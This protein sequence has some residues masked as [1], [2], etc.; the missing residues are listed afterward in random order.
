MGHVSVGV[1]QLGAAAA[2]GI[3]CSYFLFAQSAGATVVTSTSGG[4]VCVADPGSCTFTAAGTAAFTGEFVQ[5][6]PAVDPI[7]CGDQVSDSQD[8]IC[9]HFGMDFSNQTGTVTVLIA[10]DGNAADIDLCVGRGAVPGADIVGCSLG[11]GSSETVTF[12]VACTDTRFE[13]LILPIMYFDLLG[14]S[15][16]NPFPYTGSAVVT[17]LSTCT[18]GEGN[19]PPGGK[20]ATGHKITGGGK[21]SPAPATPPSMNFSLNVIA[22]ASGFKGKVQCSD[23]TTV[24]RGTEIDTVS[25]DDANQRATIFGHGFFKDAPNT[26]VPFQAEGDDQGEGSSTAPPGDIFTIDKCGGG[27]VVASGNVQYHLANA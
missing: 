16:L 3:V 18:G 24:F 20:A 15:P 14:P 26:M 7:V 5:P 1:R 11:V 10:F 25:W 27:G 9:G 12:P 19:P 23:G 4:A 17:N 21:T 6:A 8:F 22:T 13:A 2:L